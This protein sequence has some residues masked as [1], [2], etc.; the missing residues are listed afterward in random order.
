MP[1]LDRWIIF[2]YIVRTSF[3]SHPNYHLF[4]ELMHLEK[5][6]LEISNL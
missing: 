6:S 3:V 2:I 4:I 5:N 1:H